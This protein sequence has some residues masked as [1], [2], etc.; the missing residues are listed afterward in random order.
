M[1]PVIIC[2]DSGSTALGIL[3]R[4]ELC[5]RYSADDFVLLMSMT[6]EDYLRERIYDGDK[7]CAH[8]SKIILLG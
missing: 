3:K 6:D 2:S 7:L 8:P 4:D 5:A 1:T